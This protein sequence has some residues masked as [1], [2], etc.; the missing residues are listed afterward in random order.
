[1]KAPTVIVSF[2]SIFWIRRI[3]NK[4]TNNLVSYMDNKGVIVH[5][6]NDFTYEYLMKHF[7]YSATRRDDDWHPCK[8]E[9]E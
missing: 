7:E 6:T 5:S 1:L 4:D 9:I 8:K 3:N 2:P